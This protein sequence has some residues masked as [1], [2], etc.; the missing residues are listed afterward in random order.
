LGVLD[1]TADELQCFM[2]VAATMHD[3]NTLED[4]IGGCRKQVDVVFIIDKA[5]NWNYNSY[6][7]YV[8]GL[9]NAIVP[10]LLVDPTQWS[11]VAVITCS[12][13]AMV[14]FYL[15]NYTRGADVCPFVFHFTHES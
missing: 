6:V 2:I 11:Q 15:N 4:G 8:L 3:P 10:F 14:E 1:V 5:A 12:E 9:V 13:T 7:T